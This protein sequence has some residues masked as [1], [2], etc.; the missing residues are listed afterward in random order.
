MESKVCNLCQETKSFDEFNNHPTNRGGKASSCKSCYSERE[1]LKNRLKIG[2]S[3]YKPDACECCQKETVK[4][5]LD[6]CHDTGMFRGFI[7][8][9]CNMSLGVR[10]D[11]FE[12]LVEKGSDQKYL[13]YLRLANYRMGKV[14]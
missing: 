3:M 14:V 13:D 5:D 10:G 9:S 8:R 11:T 4:L 6:H 7:C 1:N 12:S 2:F